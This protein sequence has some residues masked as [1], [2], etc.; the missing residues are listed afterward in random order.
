MLPLPML[1]LLL[2]RLAAGSPQQFA[3]V[4]ASSTED[5]RSLRRRPGL[6]RESLAAVP[7]PVK[8]AAGQPSVGVANVIGQWSGESEI[9]GRV[10]HWL[11]AC[12]A[13]AGGAFQST[14]GRPR[15]RRGRA[16][17]EAGAAEVL[18]EPPTV[19]AEAAAAEQLPQ[20]QFPQQPVAIFVPV[21]QAQQSQFHNFSAADFASGA[22]WQ[23]QD[24]QPAETAPTAQQWP[25]WNVSWVQPVGVVAGAAVVQHR[26]EVPFGDVVRPEPVAAVMQPSF[27]AW[28][29]P[30]SRS[31]EAVAQSIAPSP[32]GMGQTSG[33]GEPN[34]QEAGL[35]FPPQLTLLPQKSAASSQDSSCASPKSSSDAAGLL[36]WSAKEADESVAQ[37]RGSDA[38]AKRELMERVVRSAWPTALSKHGCRVLQAALEAAD[39]AD[40]V[41]LADSFRGHVWEALRSPHANHVLQRC[42]ELLPPNRI[43]FVLGE[44]EG[45]AWEAARHRFGCRVL[46]RLLE[47]DCWRA[48]GLVTEVLHHVLDLAMHPYGNFVVQHILEHGTDEQR[49]L[50]VDALRPEVRRLARHKNAS[51]VVERALQ[52]CKQDEKQALKQAISGDA[53]ELIRLSHSNYGSFVAKAMRKR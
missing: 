15:R 21:V 45:R 39:T 43:Q 20:V 14:R 25:A 35:F 29:S 31:F 13:A 53:E 49:C 34:V 40:R 36:R 33:A 41:V 8:L 16:A 1:L 23:P 26:P 2:A 10:G 37:L 30:K 19:D 48:S 6:A 32:H 42:I 28:P 3:G 4:P 18:L 11:C 24:S 52:F 38:A 47:H 46:E 44:L 9:P 50:V 12:W 7:V 17:R 51:H 27:P 22:I 5:H